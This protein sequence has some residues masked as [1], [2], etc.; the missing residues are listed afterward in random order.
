MDKLITEIA[1]TAIEK[2]AKDV[3]KSVNIKTPQIKKE[4]WVGNYCF[5]LKIGDKK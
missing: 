2:I 4:F 3:V 1:S 5:N